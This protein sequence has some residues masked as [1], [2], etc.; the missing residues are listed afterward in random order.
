MRQLIADRKED[1]ITAPVQP[2]YSGGPLVDAH[3]AVIGVVASRL[4]RLHLARA[5]GL[6]PENINF[7][8]K[9]ELVRKLLDKIGIKYAA[10]PSEFKQL[11]VSEIAENVFKFTAPSLLRENYRGATTSGPSDGYRRV[12]RCQCAGPPGSSPSQVGQVS[13]PRTTALIYNQ[14]ARTQRLNS[15]N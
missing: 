15:S 13:G 11:A 10:P 4:N 8:V 3:G 5:A 12:C 6:L 2:G 1:Q 14:L 9:E 7:A